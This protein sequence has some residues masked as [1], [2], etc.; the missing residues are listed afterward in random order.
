[1]TSQNDKDNLAVLI[2]GDNISGRIVDSLMAEVSKYGNPTVR[3]LYGDFTRPEMGSW[4]AVLGQHAIQPVQQFA[5]SVGKNATDGKMI[6]NAMDLLHQG[7]VSAFCLVSNDSDFTSLAV[8]IREE[9]LP[10]YGFGLRRASQ[11]LKAACHA[12]I[13]LDALPPPTNAS[14]IPQLPAPFSI[15]GPGPVAPRAAPASASQ[16]SLSRLFGAEVS[17]AIINAVES[18][19]PSGRGWCAPA[20]V[21]EKMTRL[22]PGFSPE[23]YGHS[24]MIDFLEASGIVEVEKSQSNS[25]LLELLVRLEAAAVPAITNG[26]QPSQVQPLPQTLPPSPRR[27]KRSRD[28]DES[29]EEGSSKQQRRLRAPILFVAASTPNQ[30]VDWESVSN[31]L[32]Q[33]D[34][35]R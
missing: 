7:R 14:S 3:R 20:R 2:D 13:S 15:N 9:G 22:L 24:R 8:R 27:G 28:D 4:R 30:P 18:C 17:E 29:D 25:P 6:I 33:L 1:M 21:E 23:N 16:T 34:T 31:T 5:Y 10:V 12:F 35:D 19:S 32:S 26:T 11:A